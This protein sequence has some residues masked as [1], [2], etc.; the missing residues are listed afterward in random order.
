MVDG[1]TK[2]VQQR[3]PPVANG[4]TPVVAVLRISDIAT[5][6]VEFPTA[7]ANHDIR[8]FQAIPMVFVRGIAEENDRGVV[9]HVA[10]AFGNGFEFSRHAGEQG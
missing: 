6:D 3:G 1:I 4:A 8:P 7:T 10:V 5:G 9:E 2:G